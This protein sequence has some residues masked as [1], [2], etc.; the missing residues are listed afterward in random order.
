VKDETGAVIPGAAVTATS[1]SGDVLSTTSGADG[2]YSLK[3]LPNGNYRIEASYTGFAMASPVSLIEHGQDVN[4]NLVLKVS[5]VVQR[6]TVQ[7]DESATISVDSASNVSAVVLSGSKLDSLADDPNDMAADL[8]ALAGPS[9]G[10]SGGSVYIDGFSTGEMPPKENIQEIRINQNPFSPEF[11]KLG[12]G[13][14]EIITKPG[15]GNFHG[16]AFFILGSAI[17]N[18]RNPYA[19]VKAP[20]LLREFGGNLTGPLSHRASYAVNVR[21]EDTDNGAI[22]NGAVLDPTSLAIVS[23][24]TSA[25]DVAQHQVIVTSNLDYQLTKNNT[26]SIRYRA[27]DADIPDSGLGGFNLPESGYHAHSLAQTTQFV[28]T[29]VLNDNAVNETRFQFFNVSRSNV[30]LNS[31]PSIQ[32]LNA[33]TG[34]GSSAGNSSDVQRNFELQNVSTITHGPAVWHFG[35][36]VRGTIEWNTPYK[37]WGTR[38]K[39]TLFSCDICRLWGLE[40]ADLLVNLSILARSSLCRSHEQSIH[41]REEELPSLLSYQPGGAR[42]L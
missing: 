16:S 21:G 27:T 34:G 20:F 24:Y 32:V 3:H 37:Y 11:D 30:P 2:S 4:L 15:S 19:A 28:E 14:I 17:W 18:S 38:C 10:P 41:V 29:A 23:P 5:S 35:A 42:A 22:I 13:R 12:L 25:P 1:A 33:F 7:G 26:A 9:A 36:R 39:S 31:C 40:Q 6:V 8:Q